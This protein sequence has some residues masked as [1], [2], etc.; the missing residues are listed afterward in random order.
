MFKEIKKH[1]ENKK[2]AQLI[3]EL[4]RDIENCKNNLLIHAEVLS[5][6]LPKSGFMFDVNWHFN[7]LRIRE[8]SEIE[9]R[10]HT[11]EELAK[12]KE[13][14]DDLYDTYKKMIDAFWEKAKANKEELNSI[15]EGGLPLFITLTSLRSDAKTYAM[16]YEIKKYDNGEFQAYLFTGDREEGHLN[17]FTYL[18]YKIEPMTEEEFEQYYIMQRMGNTNFS[19]ESEA[20]NYDNEV[21]RLFHGQREI[22]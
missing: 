19:T 5:G 8:D 4:N 3:K 11:I 10:L 1:R 9:L 12:T 21:R 2:K 16:C 14:V 20:I 6:D 22:I 15:F 7:C 18:D 13:L 17:T